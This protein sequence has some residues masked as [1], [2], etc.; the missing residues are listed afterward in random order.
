MTITQL[1]K[2]MVEALKINAQVDWSTNETSP[3]EEFKDLIKFFKKLVKA[4]HDE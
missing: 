3:N 2:E 4:Y 1:K